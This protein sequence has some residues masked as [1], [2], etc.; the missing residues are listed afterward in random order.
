MTRVYLALAALVAAFF[1]GWASSSHMSKAAAARDALALSE[2][3]RTQEEANAAKQTKALSDYASRL[4]R[5]SSAA[6]A[7]RSDLD[8]LRGYLASS[9]PEEADSC[10]AERARI[11]SL[12]QLLSEGAGLAEE[13]GRHVEQLRADKQAL[14]ERE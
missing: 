6:A 8:R 3:L 13:G 11:R 2:Q 10:G 7:A 9:D 4:K 12:E 14:I 5:E 1:M